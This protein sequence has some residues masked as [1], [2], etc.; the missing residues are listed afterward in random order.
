MTD[1]VCPV[2]AGYLAASP[3]RKLF[4][5]PRRILGSHVQPGMTILDIGCAMGFFSLPL[6]QLVGSGGKVICV[7]LQEKMIRGLRR[8]ARK[9]GLFER[10]QTQIC[11]RESLGLDDVVEEVD[12]ALAFAVVHETPD[13]GRLFAEIHRTLKTRASVLVAEPRIHVTAA[14]FDASLSAAEQSGFDIV[15]TPAIRCSYTAVLVKK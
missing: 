1:H 4:Q 3:L 13:A 5:D 12:F 8:R 7:D 10:I 15:A 14:S 6:A 11:S 9:A 2:W